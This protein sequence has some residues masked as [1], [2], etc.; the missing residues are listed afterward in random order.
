ML[1]SAKEIKGSQIHAEDGQ[2]GTVETLYFEDERWRVRHFVVGVGNVLTNRK[3]LLSPEAICEEDKTA[4]M[5]LLRSGLTK[6]EIKNA[7]EAA[8]DPPV[9][10][11]QKNT[12]PAAWSYPVTG[13][14]TIGTVGAPMDPRTLETAGGLPPGPGEDEGFL[15]SG[16]PQGDPR[17][18]STRKMTGYR[19]RSRD[20]EIG[21]VE[22]FVVDTQRWIIRYAVVDT[23]NWLPGEKVLVASPW[24]L[25]VSFEDAEVAVDLDSIEVEEAPAWNPNMPVDRALEEKLYAHYGRTPYWVRGR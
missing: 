7:S 12:R 14:T 13:E 20:G 21:H 16:G 22:D 17:L 19:V 10:A 24:I 18:R 6:E 5:F 4:R 23:R 3:V 25:G 15:D 9:S 2:I 8:T 11:Q 1:R